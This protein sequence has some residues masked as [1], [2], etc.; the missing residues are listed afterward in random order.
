MYPDRATFQ[1]MVNEEQNLSASG[2]ETILALYD[3]PLRLRQILDILNSPDRQAAGGDK[4]ERGITESALRKR[5]ELLIERGIIARGGSERT[6]PHYYIRRPWLFNQY[7]LV[8]CR[9]GPSGELLDLPILLHELSRMA[10]EKDSL[11]HPR[12]ITA[13]GERTERGHQLESAYGSFRKLVG[14]KGAIGDYL[15]E[16]YDGIYEGRAPESDIRGLI[17]RDFLRF[18]ATASDEEREVRFFLWYANFFHI[19]DLYQEAYDAFVQGVACAERE[20]INLAAILADTRISLGHIL[21]HLNDLKGAKDAFLE[22]YRRKDSGPFLKAKSL[23]D[24][25]EVEIFCGDISPPYAPARFSQ[26]LELCKLADPDTSD[27]DVQEL[28]GDIVRRIGTVHRVLGQLDEAEACYAKA[29]T[30]YSDG[31]FRGLVWLQPERAELLR[32]RAFL[33]PAPAADKY[34]AGAAA[35]YD[36]GKNLTQRIRNINWFA[37]GLLGE[38]ELARVANLKFNKPLPKDLDAKYTNAFE[39]YSQ[40]SSR[41]GIVQTYVSQALLYHAAAETFPDKYAVTAEKIE[42]AERFSRELGLK[43]ELALIKRIKT[44]RDPSPELHPLTFL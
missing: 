23:F 33:T 31:I 27:P 20:G 3:G 21:L 17:A 26:A 4:K 35:L 32:A 25:G 34:L 13:V 9:D 7:I 12:F 10:S 5:L 37:H 30:I 2:K 36:E 40:I 15:E 16:I 6:N 19:L 42:Q 11:P 38:C 18:V 1:R 24:A 41:W 14:N 8:K 43:T 29:E 28:R 22:T 44:S 39:I